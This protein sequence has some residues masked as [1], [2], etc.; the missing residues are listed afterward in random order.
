MGRPF[1]F[2]SSRMLHDLLH[3]DSGKTPFSA[4]SPATRQ[5]NVLLKNKDKE[6]DIVSIHEGTG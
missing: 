2:A 4:K 6:I 1:F 3:Y 5:R